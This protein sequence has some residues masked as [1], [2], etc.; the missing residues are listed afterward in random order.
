MLRDYSTQSPS[1]PSIAFPLRL[2]RGLLVKTDEREAYMTLIGI[3][4]RTPR[5]SWPG[6]IAF[7]FNEF[8]SAISRH[9]LSPEQRVRIAEATAAEIN[10]VMADLALTR[11]RVDS[12]LFEPGETVRRDAKDTSPWAEV[13]GERG[14]TLMLRETGSDR[15]TRCVV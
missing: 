7:G 6:H 4:A 11:Y 14:V 9:D 15:V 3:M 13:S 2:Q 5:G 1:S 10:D 12:L 8:F